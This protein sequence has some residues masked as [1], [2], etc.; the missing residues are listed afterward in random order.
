MGRDSNPR[1]TLQPTPVFK[2]G[3]LNHSATHP[4]RILG[5]LPPGT[6]PCHSAAVPFVSVGG[7]NAASA[8]PCRNCPMPKP[9]PWLRFAALCYL[10]TPSLAAEQLKLDPVA[11]AQAKLEQ[12]QLASDQPHT[13]TDAMLEFRKTA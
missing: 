3:A 12:E 2:T 11:A 8:P 10:S 1:W 13:L 5:C 7:D 6:N 4:F 9:H